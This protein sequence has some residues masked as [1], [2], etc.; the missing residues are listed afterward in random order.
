MEARPAGK[1][2][3]LASLVGQ[4]QAAL[5]VGQASQLAGP[6]SWPAWAPWGSPRPGAPLGSP[7]FPGARRDSPGLPGAPGELQGIL[8]LPGTPWDS[9]GLPG[10]FLRAP[11]GAAPWEL[12]G[13]PQGAQ[14]TLGFPGAPWA[15]PGSPWEP[16]RAQGF[17]GAPG[18]LAIWLTG[19]LM[20]H[21]CQGWL[22]FYLIKRKA[23]MLSK[24]TPFLQATCMK[25]L[26]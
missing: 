15:S 1:P 18:G 22:R 12:P 23:C 19:N 17:P 9:L 8:G 21:R 11:Q 6:A 7:E 3:A 16:R 20:T 13:D 2:A 24:S 10:K 5:P 26:F 14:G 25:N 4:G